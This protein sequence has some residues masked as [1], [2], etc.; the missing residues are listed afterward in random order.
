M[1][2]Y[3]KLVAQYQCKTIVDASSSES[4]SDSASASANITSEAA[5]RLLKQL[6]QQQNNQANKEPS[7]NAEDGGKRKVAT[8]R[9]PTR[10]PDPNV[11]NRNALL[12]RENR[13]KKKAHMEAVE[14]ELN[15][16]RNANKSLLKALK[17]QFKLT[18]K[19]AKE[20]QHLKNRLGN[21]KTTGNVAG[22][23][24]NADCLPPERDNRA[25]SPDG[26][27]ISTY[28]GSSYE[29]AKESN[30]LA[31]LLQIDNGSVAEQR[32]LTET[33]SSSWNDFIDDLLTD[34]QP[35][36]EYENESSTRFLEQSGFGFEECQTPLSPLGVVDEH[37]YFNKF[38]DL[39]V[40][41]SWEWS[42]SCTPPSQLLQDEDFANFSSGE[43][44]ASL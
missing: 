8:A 2:E 20:C 19:L 15:E 9:L 38:S 33:P 4:D 29:P 21:C 6:Q 17:K 32:V 43:C 28:S 12:A 23:C 14:R 18:Q 5:V 16:T 26:S 34:Y 44:I 3:M 25:V 27:L 11:Y 42:A 13:R 7:Q 10:R 30:C 22:P 36:P 37:S 24:L 1:E 39:G 35:T 31:G 40:S 41:P